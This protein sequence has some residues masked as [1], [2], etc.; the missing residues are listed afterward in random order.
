[1]TIFQI[2]RCD[3]NSEYKHSGDNVYS[4]VKGD[5]FKV[6][7]K[8]DVTLVTPPTVYV[9][10]NDKTFNHDFTSDVSNVLTDSSY[11]AAKHSVNKICPYTGEVMKVIENMMYIRLVVAYPKIETIMRQ[12]P[13]GYKRFDCYSNDSIAAKH[14][15]EAYLKE[16]TPPQVSAAA[17]A[18]NGTTTQIVFQTFVTNCKEKKALCM[19]EEAHKTCNSCGCQKVDIDTFDG[20]DDVIQFWTNYHKRHHKCCLTE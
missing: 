8:R 15:F 18:P 14:V 10:E 1:M 20:I 6:I 7:V 16:V 19:Y 3:D 17:A 11:K 4:I 2:I 5:E 9:F 13:G 12:H